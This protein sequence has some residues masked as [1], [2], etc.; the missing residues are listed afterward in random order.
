MP[1]QIKAFSQ[2]DPASQQNKTIRS[3]GFC[4]RQQIDS[5]TSIT[6]FTCRVHFF[7]SKMYVLVLKQRQCMRLIKIIFIVF[8]YLLQ[9]YNIKINTSQSNLYKSLYSQTHARSK[10]VAMGGGLF[11]GSGGIA[12]SAQKFCIFVAKIT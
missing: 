12:R 2:L 4:Y 3:L 9:N 11:Q 10:K 5:K 8:I 6:F 1:S 7:T